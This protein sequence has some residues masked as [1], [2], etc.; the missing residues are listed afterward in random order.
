MARRGARIAMWAAALLTLAAVFAAYLD[1][2]VMVS[3]ANQLWAC[4]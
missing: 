1:P 4:F 2:H 3:L